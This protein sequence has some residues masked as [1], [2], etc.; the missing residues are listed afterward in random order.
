MKV[1]F[2]GSGDAFGTGGRNQ[3][4][5]LAED[6][7]KTFLIDCG[8][9]SLSALKRNNFDINKIDF[10]LNTHLHGDHFGGIPF[11]LLDFAVNT[12][13]KR[14]LNI[15]GPT[16]IAKRIEDTMEMLFPGFT[17]ERFGFKINFFELKPGTTE[18]F[19]GYKIESFLMEHSSFS[20]C[21]GYKISSD[22]CS[23]A[24]TGDSGW[25]DKVFQLADG[26]D[27]FICECSF[28]RKNPVIKHISMN[29]LTENIENIKTKRLVLTH[30]SQ[31]MI[32]NLDKVS[33]EVAFD[34]LE[35]II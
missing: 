25:I 11:L 19:E 16:G 23:L 13:R 33:F 3:T 22:K 29:E 7:E 20:D 30:L 34:N 27:L 4:C 6:K 24:Y 31:D 15:Y 26:T 12:I 21:M 5:F 9:A 28:F 8:P 2:I 14:D 10:I 18:N 17:F 35:I 32:N 1:T